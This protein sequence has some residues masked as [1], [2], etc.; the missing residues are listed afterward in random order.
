VWV[1]ADASLKQKLPLD[2][3]D[4]WPTITEGKASPHTEILLNATPNTGAMRVGDW[5]LVLNGQIGASENDGAET[6]GVNPPSLELFN[7]A[8][9][10]YEKKNLAESD[11][12]QVKKLR[13]RYEHLATQAVAPKIKP[14]APDFRS[15]KVWGEQ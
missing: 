2:G 3:H 8:D 12:D 6:P 13:A 10:P 5:K 14:K 15:P 9:D 4:A 1:P 11:P 7:L